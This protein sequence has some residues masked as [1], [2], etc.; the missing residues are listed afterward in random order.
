MKTTIVKRRLALFVAII[1]ALSLWTALPLQASAESSEAEITSFSFEIEGEDV[2]ISEIVDNAATITVVLPYGTEDLDSLEPEIVISADAEIDK[3]GEQDFSDGTV[4]YTVTA[5]DG[6]TT[7]T[8]TV[9]VSVA[10]A[11][12]AAEITSF[13]FEIE[14]EDVD[15][16][17]IVEKAATITVVLPYGTEDLDRKSVV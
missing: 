11:S 14:G 15:I 17:E 6:E 10:P 2:D 4:D 9:S 13:S 3:T 7:T 12:T 8:Y 5:Q 1:M 16:S